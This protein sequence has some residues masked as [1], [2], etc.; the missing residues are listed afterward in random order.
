VVETLGSSYTLNDTLLTGT[1]EGSTAIVDHLEGI[2]VANLVG[3]EIG[4]STAFNVDSW[5]GTGSLT[6]PGGS[7]G[8]VTAFK[9]ANFTLTNT[10]LQT[11]DGMSLNLNP[12]I[13]WIADLDV[14][15]GVGQPTAIIDASGFSAGVTNLSV[16]GP[17]NAIVYGGSG[18]GGT[19][20]AAGSGK[21]VLIGNGADDVLSDTGTGRNILIGAG[22]GGDT[23]VGSGGRNDILVSGTTEY[24]SH[25]GANIAALEAILAEWGSSDSYA[26]RITKIKRGVVH[27]FSP[28]PRWVDAFNS[29]TIHTDPNVNTLSDGSIF[30]LQTD[31][32]DARSVRKSSLPRRTI[33]IRHLVSNNWFIVS[34]QDHVTAKPN[35][36]RTII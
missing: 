14:V 24:D 9:G 3:G 30:S 23:L 35:E 19:L 4:T 34:R 12:A 2:K 8:T 32:A 26:N 36:T 6:V 18:G 11:S 31:R 27:Q 5:T 25:T 29:R 1:F 33:P 21:D 22:S 7:V 17:G 10:L 16:L 13:A 28:L 20:T 15:T